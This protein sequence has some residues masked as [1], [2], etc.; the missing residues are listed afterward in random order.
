MSEETKQEN[1]ILETEFDNIF[2]K[3]PKPVTLS[4]KQTYVLLYQEYVE[5][6]VVLKDYLTRPK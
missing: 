2:N 4:E 1:S 6:M 5:F 3:I